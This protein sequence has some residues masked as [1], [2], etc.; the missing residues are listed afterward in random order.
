MSFK[1]QPLSDVLGAELTGLDARLACSPPVQDSLRAALFRHQVLA[2]R[3][4][5]LTPQQF[6]AFARNFGELE[7]FFTNAYSLPDCPEI[8]VLSNVRRAGRPIGRDGAGTH[9]HSDH[10]FQREPAI[11]TL[12]YA[13]DVPQQGGETLFADMYAAYEALPDGEKHR[14][15]G[16][17]ALH[18][19]QKKEHLYT[20]DPAQAAAERDGIDRLRA[21]RQQE[22]AAISLPA[23]GLPAAGP[24]AAGPPAAA[25]APMPDQ[26]HPVVRTHPV[27]GRKALYLNDEMTVGIDGM[28]DAE[29]V[30]LL[31]RLC[32]EATR[33]EHV[34]RYRWRRGDIVIW[35]NPSVL[36]AATYTDPAQ[37]R[38]LYRLT[39]KGPEPC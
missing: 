2:I 13:V 35:D 20:A 1:A 22:E 29:A 19:Y 16:R 27:T 8:Y 4:Q 28:P 26:R 11:A 38:T 7:P 10:T 33:P 15:G 24:P 18:R 12:L 3:D 39:I 31:H 21:L 25:K 23:A 9:W 34:F 5:V 17:R 36:H 32:A 6:V 30:E 14:L 37:P